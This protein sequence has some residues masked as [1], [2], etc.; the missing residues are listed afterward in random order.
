[1]DQQS[2]QQRLW[3]PALEAFSCAAHWESGE[4]WEVHINSRCEAEGWLPARRSG[5]SLLTSP[6]LADVVCEELYRRL[7]L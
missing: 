7:R 4:G 5:Y 2:S 3:Q 1:M 6:E